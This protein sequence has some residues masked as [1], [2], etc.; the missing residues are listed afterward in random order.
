[1]W[2]FKILLLFYLNLINIHQKFKS[3][4][5]ILLFI[6]RI[7]EFDFLF[8]IKKKRK[9]YQEIKIIQN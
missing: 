3:I 9:I 6:N 1:M 2:L 4:K 5:H 7:T 8:Y